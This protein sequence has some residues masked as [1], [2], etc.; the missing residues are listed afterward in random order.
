MKFILE[1]AEPVKSPVFIGCRFGE[2][3]DVCI[4][5]ENAEGKTAHLFWILRSGR[6]LPVVNRNSLLALGFEVDDNGR[7]VCG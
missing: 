1:K 5:A 2:E 3:G 7:V 6:T 4:Y